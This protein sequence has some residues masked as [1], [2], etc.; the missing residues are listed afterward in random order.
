MRKSLGLKC[1]YC[2]NN[3]DWGSHINKPMDDNNFLANVEEGQPCFC[4]VCKEVGIYW[5]GNVIE[6]DEKLLSIEQK[7]DIEE[8]RQALL[9]IEKDEESV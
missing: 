4:I 2:K 7:K 1:P 5:K 9:K 8:I 3:F 6:L